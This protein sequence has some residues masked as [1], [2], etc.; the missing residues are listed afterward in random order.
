MTKLVRMYDRQKKTGYQNRAKKQRWRQAA[1]L[2][3]AAS[4]LTM[5]VGC[6]I[7]PEE[8][9][10]ERAPTVVAYT[11]SPY[12]YTSI[13]R[14]DIEIRESIRFEYE[15]TEEA[16]LAF[17][18][19]GLLFEGIYVNQGSQV[20]EGQILIELDSGDLDEQIAAKD[21][22]IVRAELEKEQA[23]ERQSLERDRLELDL[24]Y[25][26][27]SAS[28]RQ[29][30]LKELEERQAQNLQSLEDQLYILGLEKE[31]LERL[32]DERRIVAPYDATVSYVRKIQEGARSASGE[33]LVRVVVSESSMFVGRTSI[34]EYFPV[35]GEILLTVGEDEIPVEVVEVSESTE[36]QRDLHHVYLKLTADEIV[37]ETGTRGNADILIDASRDTLLMD[38][39][40]L[41]FAEEIPFVYVESE[42]GL[43]E[44]RYIE[45]GLTT[46]DLVE[47]T[48]GLEEGERVILD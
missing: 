42:D 40:A 14:G 41:H 21:A 47:V 2:T 26:G 20:K 32:L 9:V 34:P 43:P 12:E 46:K 27:A 29:L 17:S 13:Q 44:V 11:Q 45:I 36:G 8:P 1:L 35:G 19:G 23:E 22:A 5:T 37:L 15:P 6:G 25:Q 4:T 3:I 7:L 28:D 18:I 38:V 31:Q 33:T 10:Y 24:K 48:S 30:R 39:D 16:A